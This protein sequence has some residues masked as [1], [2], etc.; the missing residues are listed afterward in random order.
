MFCKRRLLPNELMLKRSVWH[1]WTKYL[2]NTYTAGWTRGLGER[3]QA[4]I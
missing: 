3:Q 1:F 2:L 4:C